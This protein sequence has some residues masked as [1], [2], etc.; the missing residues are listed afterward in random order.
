MGFFGGLLDWWQVVSNFNPPLSSGRSSYLEL[1]TYFSVFDPMHHNVV[2]LGI[3][4][5]WQVVAFLLMWLHLIYFAAW[6][7]EIR[8]YRIIDYMGWEV[9]AELSRVPML[10][11]AW[12]VICAYTVVPLLGL[13][14]VPIILGSPIMQLVAKIV[15]Q[16]AML[17]IYD[18]FSWFINMA[19]HLSF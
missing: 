6:F 18:Y 3:A 19:W 15:G 7:P 12:L 5:V 8:G 16:N 14:S 1:L 4:V 9:A 11:F 13:F 17:D 10:S 2:W